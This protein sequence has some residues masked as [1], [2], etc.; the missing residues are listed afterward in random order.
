M[1]T[2]TFILYPDGGRNG[3]KGNKKGK[4]EELKANAV[5]HNQAGFVFKKQD[6]VLTKM[7]ICRNA[8]HSNCFNGNHVH[9]LFR[10]KPKR[11]F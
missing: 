2:K 10:Y 11:I 4:D 6:E 1:L 3:R 7:G 8:F 9:K 5:F